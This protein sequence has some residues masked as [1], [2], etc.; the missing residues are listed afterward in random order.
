MMT[1]RSMLS[2][3]CLFHV[4]NGEI[5]GVSP[6]NM[7]KYVSSSEF[8]CFDRSKTIKMDQ[9]NDEFCDCADGSDEPGTSACSYTNIE[10]YC[11]NE[12]YFAKS[13]PTSLIGDGICDCCDGSDENKG[14]C[15]NLCLQQLEDQ[16]NQ[17]KERLK[18]VQTGANIRETRLGEVN[19]RVKEITDKVEVWDVEKAQIRTL[20]AKVLRFK[21]Y[22]EKRELAM[23]IASA[24]K[25]KQPQQCDE[26]TGTCSAPAT[27]EDFDEDYAAE[28]DKSQGLENQ[29]VRLSD[30][31]TVPLSVYFDQ[32]LGKV[33]RAESPDILELR[34]SKFLGPIFNGGEEGPK[35]AAL[36]IL[37]VLGFVLLPIRCIWEIVSY[38]GLSL[39]ISMSWSIWFRQIFNGKLYRAYRILQWVFVALWDGP[40]TVYY[41]FLYVSSC[42]M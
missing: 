6:E 28:S 15:E 34:R 40:V 4:V 19:A 29:P 9:I 22:E 41:Y 42:S 20:R 24:E 23:Q 13:I 38:F 10:F 18:Q 31:S 39:D 36:A 33:E 16:R 17:A 37:S 14:F 3:L 8:T 26:A 25:K 12:Q 11:R 27:E 21:A 7:H 5:E 1:M 32:T 2:L 30:K 35:R